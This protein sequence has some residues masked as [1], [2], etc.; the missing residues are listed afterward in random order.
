METVLVD[1]ADE[2]VPG[3]ARQS[4]REIEDDERVTVVTRDA[5]FPH[6]P[7]P[8]PRSDSVTAGNW[9]YWLETDLLANDRFRVTITLRS[10][11]SEQR[12]STTMVLAAGQR[13]VLPTTLVSTRGHLAVVLRSEAV[14]SK[15]ELYQMLARRRGPEPDPYE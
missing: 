7:G 2:D 10:Y 9:Q 3:L 6:E 12:V 5:A 8:K 4:F 11:L 14:H 13:L 15:A 1:V